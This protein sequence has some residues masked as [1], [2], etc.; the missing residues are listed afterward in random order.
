MSSGSATSAGNGKWIWL[1]QL[2]LSGGIRERRHQ[3]PVRQAPKSS[4]KRP[5]DKYDCWKVEASKISPQPQQFFSFRQFDS[6]SGRSHYARSNESSFF[7]ADD[8]D[9]TI[10]PLMLMAYDI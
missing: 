10:R 9:N 4:E 7:D 6:L 5:S 2:S 1:R 3:S 8:H